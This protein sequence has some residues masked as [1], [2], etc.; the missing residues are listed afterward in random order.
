MK[1][2]YAEYPA[3]NIQL[4]SNDAISL[5]QDSTDEMS[6]SVS[7]IPYSVRLEAWR[8]LWKSSER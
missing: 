1:L 5:A 7:R 2:S 8:K 4:A 3:A 6:L